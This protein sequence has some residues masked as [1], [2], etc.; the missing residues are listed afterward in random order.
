MNEGLVEL[1]IPLT[2]IMMPVF[3]VLI[4]SL[5][6]ARDK[7]SRYDALVEISKNTKDSEQ[8]V[9]ILESLVEK[10]K[11]GDIRKSGVVTIFA[12]VGI[13]LF[14]YYG[15]TNKVIY[16]AGLLVAFVG[17]GQMIAGYIYPNQT[18]EINRAVENFEKK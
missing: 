9:E 3:I 7:K 1:L 12:G 4:V 15:L 8:S 2:A 16:G 18:D 17:I 13:F 6:K 14:G 10:Q 5:F 11:T